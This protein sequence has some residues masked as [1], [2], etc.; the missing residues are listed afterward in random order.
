MIHLAVNKYMTTLYYVIGDNEKQVLKKKKK[1]QK[2][3]DLHIIFI[4]WKI[5]QYASFNT[6]SYFLAFLYRKGSTCRYTFFS[7]LKLLMP[8]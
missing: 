1:K 8:I 7:L 6:S 2:I 3:M 4:S 5:I